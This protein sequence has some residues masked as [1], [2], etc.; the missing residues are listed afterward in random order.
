MRRL[1]F[2]IETTLVPDGPGRKFPDRVHCGIVRDLDNNDTWTFWPGEVDKL[3]HLLNRA[4]LLA[5]HNIA[6]FDLPVLEHHFPEIANFTDRIIDTLAVSRLVYIS[7]LEQRSWKAR[8]A[9]GRTPEEREARLPKSMCKKHTLESWG[10]RLK[11]PKKFADVEPEFFNE[12]SEDMLARCRSDVILNQRLLDHLLHAS[13][14]EGWPVNP[15]EALIV[16][17]QFLRILGAQE[18]N[19]VGFDEAKAIELHVHLTEREAELKASVSQGVDPWYAP[20]GPKAGRVTPKRSARSRNLKPGEPGYRN[21]AAGCGYTKVKRVVFNPGSGMHIERVLRRRYGWEP[22]D[23][24]KTGQAKTDEETLADLPYPI[25][26]ELLAYLTTAKRLGQLAEGKAAWLKAA[27]EKRIYGSVH[28]TGTRTSRCSHFKP[29]LGQVPK[30]LKNPETNEIMLG[31]EGR[32]GAESRELFTPTRPGW[33]MVGADASGLELRCL[34][35]YLAYFDDGAFAA[36]LLGGD[37]HTDWMKSTGI[38]IRDNQ[39]TFTYAMLYGAGDYKLGLIRLYDWRMAVEQGL[40]T[41]AVPGLRFASEVGRRS[42]GKLLSDLTALKYL[43][44]RCRASFRKGWIRSIDGR[45]LATKSEHGVLNDILQSAGAVA[46]KHAAVHLDESLRDVGVRHGE[47]FGYMLNVH[48]EWQIE[49]TPENAEFIGKAMVA[50]IKAAGV[51]LG[52]RLPLDGE[53]KIGQ[54]WKETH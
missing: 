16:E 52:F 53:Y 9:G 22:Q 42:R 28:A 18:R 21:V 7:N 14:N 2:D 26:P 30:V 46:M 23:F 24:T 27:Y 4:D 36:T 8:N 13:T 33:V 20:D 35:H 6:G 37:P 5:G 43:L 15:L 31:I 34:A 48:D 45:V 47:D 39:K 40:T 49:T 17:S 1:L 19:G 32:Y 3:V 50:S 29:N 41:K 12:F 44:G 25:I 51:K 38:W 54:N 11:V 10:Y